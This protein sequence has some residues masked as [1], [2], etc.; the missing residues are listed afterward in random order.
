MMITSVRGWKGLVV[1]EKW[2]RWL[3]VYLWREEARIIGE[4]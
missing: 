4:W 1:R 2:G 3:K